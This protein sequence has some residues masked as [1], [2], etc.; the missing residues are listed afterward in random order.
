M[1][2]EIFLVGI[3]MTTIGCGSANNTVENPVMPPSGQS[4]SAGVRAHGNN[5]MGQGP[6]KKKWSS[7]RGTAIDTTMLDA[8]IEKAKREHDARPADQGKT[9]A[10]AKA[11]VSRGTALTEAAQYA[12]ALGDFRRALKLDPGNTE[13]QA[14]L[15]QIL[16]IYDQLNIQGPEPGEEPPPKPFTKGT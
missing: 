11:Y 8:A 3:L 10:L 9:L 14:Q 6:V 15:N 12:S 4:D 13:A 16:K 7:D 1:K 5:P 2:K